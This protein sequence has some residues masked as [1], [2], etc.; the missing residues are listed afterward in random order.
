VTQPAGRTLTEADGYYSF[1]GLTPGTYFVKV[2]DGQLRKL[3]MTADPEFHKIV[4]TGS[5]D[6]DLEGGLDFVLTELATDTVAD[7]I[8]V[9][10]SVTCSWSAEVGGERTPGYTRQKNPG[11]GS[12]KDQSESAKDSLTKKADLHEPDEFQ[13]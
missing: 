7:T 12:A 11:S 8:T 4:N 5:V 10:K 1:L 2:D 3:N 9:T 6:G 13:V